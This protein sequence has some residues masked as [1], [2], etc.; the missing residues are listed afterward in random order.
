MTGLFVPELNSS[1]IRGRA[2]AAAMT[3]HWLANV[4]LGQTFIAAVDQYGLSS[5]YA[6]FGGVAL[7]GALY[8]GT[9][10]GCGRGGWGCEGGG[11]MG[12]HVSEVWGVYTCGGRLGWIWCGVRPSCVWKVCTGVSSGRMASLGT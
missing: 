1:K 12:V 7:L 8:V 6:F 3:S 5:V 4:A 2:V 11:V 10:V 9:Q